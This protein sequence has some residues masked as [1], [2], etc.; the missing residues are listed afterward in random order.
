M[1][2]LIT[3]NN[4]NPQIIHDFICEAVDREREYLNLVCDTLPAGEVYSRKDALYQM[5]AFLILIRST[6]RQR[7]LF[8]KS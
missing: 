7:E 2:S 6:G 5:S 3:K 1:K 4:L 8:N